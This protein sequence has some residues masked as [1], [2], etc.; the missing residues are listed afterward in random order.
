MK[1]NALFILLTLIMIIACAIGL[2]ACGE[3]GSAGDGGGANID[4]S[5]TDNPNLDEGVNTKPSTPS[6]ENPNTNIPNPNTPNIPS[7]EKP[8]TNLPNAEKPSVTKPNT[9]KPSVGDKIGISVETAYAKATE[10][11]YAGSREEFTATVSG[12]GSSADV[13]VL[14]IQVNNNG[15]LIILLTNGKTVNMGKVVCE[16]TYGKWTVGVAPTCTSIGYNTRVCSKCDDK[17]YDFVEAKGHTFD[18]GV[19][20]IQPLC[21][22]DGMALYTCTE[23]GVA[24]SEVLEKI[25][26]NY[27]SGKCTHCNE[28]EPSECLEFSL[29]SDGTYYTVRRGNT[30]NRDKITSIVIPGVYNG[31]PV[32]QIKDSILVGFNNL[33]VVV[34]EEGVKVLG[35]YAFVNC[36]NLE[37]VVIPNS[38]EKIG[39]SAFRLS[40]LKNIT[41][42]KTVTTIGNYIM[43]GCKNLETIVVEEG[44]PIY[45]SANN[46]LIETESKTLLHGTNM[47]VIPDD[48]SVTTIAAFAFQY[49]EELESITI[50]SSV[51][52][53]GN[54]AFANCYM[55]KEVYNY[56]DLDIVAG[57]STHGAV[58]YYALHVYTST[59]DDSVFITTADGFVF[60]ND[61]NRYCLVGYSGEATDITLPSY[62]E[63]NKYSIH[64]YAFYKNARI[65]SVV[66]PSE[67]WV[68]GPYAFGACTNLRSAKIYSSGG[69]DNYAF[70]NCT[71]LESVEIAGV[72]KDICSYAFYGCTSLVDVS[73]GDGIK[74]LY[75]GVFQNCTSLKSV[76]I[77]DS[78]TYMANRVFDS[79][80]SLESVTLSKNVTEI[81]DYTFNGCT[82]L[83]NI[84]IFDGVTR[85]GSNAFAQCDN[86]TEI[87]IP[88]SVT[89]IGVSALRCCT[90]LKKA[91]VGRGVTVVPNSMF[92]YCP[93]LEK[94]TLLGDV[95]EIGVSA[96]DRCESLK[97]MVIP[98]S[99]VRIDR[100][101]FDDCTSLK[102]VIFEDAKGWTRTSYYHSDE[103]GS[104][105]LSVNVVSNTEAVAK[106]LKQGTICYT[107]LWTKEVVDDTQNSGG[108]NANE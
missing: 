85:I 30:G 62:F 77:P 11:G 34:I 84:V 32:A 7:V 53:I 21:Y 46:C 92:Y 57:T 82:N 97:Y 3:S 39:D 98:A 60:A 45:H 73:I 61:G 23:C 58:A 107:Y 19:T 31:L 104:E 64:K 33:K 17:D 105:A 87:Y 69:I 68:I 91:I 40:G 24:K 37:S 54:G 48:G 25:G 102:N 41:I 67:V 66:V 96:F 108:G 12:T 89:E 44:N 86:L 55:L 50:P 79:C 74:G 81:P 29:S 2:V 36:K 20:L 72:V 42:P 76:V 80:A 47:S 95:T 90:G 88:D 106:L 9:E 35:R 94:V 63:G 18:G 5:I 49:R 8:N 16:H 15:E 43:A 1:K 70:Q 99:V 83:K 27:V 78:V 75:T 101:A 13:S 14:G 28:T 59:D 65:T 22:K 10:L 52:S 71:S 56:S 4:N 93:S 103:E 26:H 38:V 6:V 51:T 100:S